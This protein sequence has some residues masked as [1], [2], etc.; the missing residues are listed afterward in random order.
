MTFEVS[1][2]EHVLGGSLVADRR[3]YL[4]VDRAGVVE[5]GDFRAAFLLAGAGGEI[6]ARDAERLGLSLVNGRISLKA[7][8]PTPNK[9][10]KVREDK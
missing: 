5:E 10:R 1:G 2:R 9:A 8:A 7:K 6:P 3:L 4:T